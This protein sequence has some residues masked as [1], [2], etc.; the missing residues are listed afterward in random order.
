MTLTQQ[1]L[2]LIMLVMM[3]LILVMILLMLVMR[4]MMNVRKRPNFWMLKK[5]PFLTGN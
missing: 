4:L 1:R 2:M 3:L 5:D